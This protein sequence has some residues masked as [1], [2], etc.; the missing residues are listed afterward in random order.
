M[1]T[2]LASAGLTL[3]HDA[4]LNAAGA[5]LAVNFLITEVHFITMLRYDRSV[6]ESTVLRVLAV[7]AMF[8]EILIL[9]P[10]FFY[11][12]IDTNTDLVFSLAGWGFNAISLVCF[13]ISLMK[14]WMIH[15]QM[16]SE[17]RVTSQ[18]STLQWAVGLIIVGTVVGNW[19][20]FFSLLTFI[21][22]CMYLHVLNVLRKSNGPHVTSRMFWA[23]IASILLLVVM[24][25]LLI[26]MIVSIV[27]EAANLDSNGHK[28]T[29]AD[30]MH[31]WNTVKGFLFGIVLLMVIINYVTLLTTGH[32]IGDACSESP[33]LYSTVRGEDDVQRPTV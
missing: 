12:S 1:S 11:S 19:V 30:A 31:L 15:A 18:Q 4:M 21:G 10:F 33:A 13:A 8:L 16:F 32:Y 5:L 24:F 6:A 25:I 27:N 3:Q 28:A 2:S 20:S 14:T 26:V 22:F 23:Q 17:G 7:L 9:T 29:T